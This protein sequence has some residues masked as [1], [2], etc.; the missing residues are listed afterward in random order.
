MFERNPCPSCEAMPASGRRLVRR[1]SEQAEYAA[2]LPPYERVVGLH[3]AQQALAA[4]L[5]ARTAGMRSD[6][7][8]SDRT[9]LMQTVIDA[10]AKHRALLNSPR[11]VY[12]AQLVAA[13]RQVDAALAE[14]AAHD[15]D[16][17]RA[18][19]HTEASA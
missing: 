10:V 11:S 17:G 15:F 4:A 2:K 9:A 1:L 12:T 14:L 6:E 16:S 18:A 5:I 7:P 19:S 3:H 8:L 13:T